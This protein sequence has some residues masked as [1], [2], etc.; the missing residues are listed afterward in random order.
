MQLRSFILLG[1]CAVLGMG[2][3]AFA[4]PAN[5]ATSPSVETT[6]A[7]PVVAAKSDASQLRLLKKKKNPTSDDLAQISKLEAKIV[8][9][10]EAAKQ[11]AL[12]ARKLAMREA[13]KA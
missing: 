1:V 3:A 13:A 8:A 11:K 12:E 2:S 10:K 4:G 9:D 5:L 7:I 6:D